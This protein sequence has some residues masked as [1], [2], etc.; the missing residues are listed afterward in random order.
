[1]LNFVFFQNREVY[2]HEYR[3]NSKYRKHKYR[4]ILKKRQSIDK[5][6]IVK[7]SKIRKYRKKGYRKKIPKPASIVKK[8]RSMYRKKKNNGTKCESLT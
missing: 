8:L 1:M 4:K 7:L 5:S 3:E 2:F 6:C